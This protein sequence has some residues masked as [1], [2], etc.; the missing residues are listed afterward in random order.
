MTRRV[1]TVLSQLFLFCSC[2]AGPVDGPSHH[3]H[4]R[5][6]CPTPS[7]LRRCDGDQMAKAP[8]DLYPPLAPHLAEEVQ[9]KGARLGSPSDPAEV[10]RRAAKEFRNFLGVSRAGRKPKKDADKSWAKIS[11]QMEI[12]IKKRKTPRL[13]DFYNATAWA[14]L[15]KEE[16]PEENKFLEPDAIR[17]HVG[18]VLKLLKAPDWK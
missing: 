18:V 14:G 1:F 5:D 10:G 16:F 15:L 3:C 12:L 13:A 17:K 4:R 2:G 11:K 6:A 7:F 9:R 8:N